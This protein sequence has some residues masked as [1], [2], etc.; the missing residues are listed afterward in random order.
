M[1]RCAVGIR[2]YLRCRPMVFSHTRPLSSSS[3]KLQQKV[4]KPAVNPVLES[5]RYERKSPIEHILL[6]PDTYVGSTA[7]AED[8]DAWVV[9]DDGTKC[10][11]TPVTYSPALLKI[12]DEILVNAADNKQRDPDMD[13]LRVD[14]DQKHGTISIVNNGRGLPIEVHPIEGIYVPTLIFGN[15]FTSSNYDDSEVKVVGGRNGYGAKLCNIFSKEFI[16]ETSSKQKG[17]VFRQRWTNNMRECAEPVVTDDVNAMDYT[18]VTFCPDVS[19]FGMEVLDDAICRMFHKRTYDVAGTLR[20]VNVFYNGQ[21]V[22]V[23]SFREYVSLYSDDSA[24]DLL[25]VNASRRWQWAVKRTSGGFQQISFVNNIATTGGGKHVDHVVDQL[26]NIIK[27][28]VDANVKSGVKRVAIK[29]HLCLFVNALIENPAFNSQTKGVLTTPVSDF[30]S[31]CAV[32]SAVVREWAERSGLVDELTSDTLAREARPQRKQRKVVS[33]DLSDIVKLED[34]NWAGNAGHMEECRLL[35]TEGDSAKAL[36]VA[37]LEVV[38]RDRYGV[39]PIMG[40]LTNVSG[41][42]EEKA[43]SAKEINHLIR[44]LGLKYGTD[45]SLRKNRQSLRYG[46]VIILTD[47]DEDGAHIKGLIINFLHTF[48]PQLIRC[49]FVQSFRTPLLKARRGSETI[50]FYSAAEFNEWK[51][52]TSDADKFTIKYYKGLGTSTSK[53]AREYFSNFQQHLTTFR[54]EDD[55]D[56]LRIR[57]VFDK[58]RSDDRK[59]W[60]TERLAASSQASAADSAIPTESRYKDFVDNELFRYSILDLRRSIPSVVDGLKPS[61]RKVIHTL[62][63]RSSNKEIKVNQLAAAV[64]LHDAYHHGEI[65]PPRARRGAAPVGEQVQHLY[66][67]SSN[68]A[69][70]PGGLTEYLQPVGVGINK[71]FMD[72]IEEATLVRN[73]LFAIS[74]ET[75]VNS[76]KKA[77]D[78]DSLLYEQFDALSVVDDELEAALVTTIVRLA[79]DFVGMNNVCLLEPLGQFGTRH[80]GGDDAASARY[81]YTKLSAFT[82][83]IFPPADDDLL[84]YLEEE[85]QSIEPQWYCPIVP[86]ILVNGAEGIATGWST[87][88]L[89]HNIRKVIDNVRRLID[90][91]KLEKMIPSFADFSGTVE[92]LE[93]NRYEIRGRFRFPPSQRK[94]APNLNLDIVELPV[95]EWTNRYKQ[96]TLHTLQSRGLISEPSAKGTTIA[97]ERAGVAHITEPRNSCRGKFAE[98]RQLFLHLGEARDSDTNCVSCPPCRWPTNCGFK[99]YHTE[100]GV[101]FEVELSKEFSVRCRKPIGRHAELMKIFKLSTVISTN[102]MVLFDPNGQLKHYAAVSDIMH[103]HFRTRQKK[104]E[105]RREYEAK[106]LDAQRRRVE[107]QLRFV[108]ATVSGEIRPQGSHLVDLENVML[109]KGFEAD[110]VK[111]WKNEKADLSY[112]LGMPL[113]RLTMEEIEKLRNQVEAS[114]SK[115]NKVMQT[116]WQDLWLED[117][118]ALEKMSGDDEEDRMCYVCSFTPEVTSDLLEELFTQVGPVEK[119]SLTDK[120]SHRF[121]MVTFEDEES[122]LFAVETL[123]GIKLFDT[124]LTV[125]PRNGSK[126]EKEYKMN[127]SAKRRESYGSSHSSPHSEHRKRDYMGRTTSYDESYTHRSGGQTNSLYTPPPPP[128]PPPPPRH[129]DSYPSFKTRTPDSFNTP[130]SSF[131]GRPGGDQRRTFPSKPSDARVFDGES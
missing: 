35:I 106:M 126:H 105:E 31:K 42:S 8:V 86:M 47:Q 84:E 29:N 75:T 9:S 43:N 67:E 122:V 121:A 61:Q 128:P 127:L 23:S 107:N 65:S 13:E 114:R 34:A 25:Y 99:E 91:V 96:N 101:H 50:S 89:S 131:T 93:E 68:V 4:K 16:V 40:K 73:N 82:R 38:G 90:N 120:K 6:R 49:G 15:L 48:W 45:Y 119:V 88:I 57:L 22:K 51:R 72:N 55:D 100:R 32:D 102:S 39:F 1:R 56:D 85:N 5:L 104:Y 54:H 11:Q 28:L 113:S 112:L 62:L 12:F 3:L 58:R 116:S 79:Q 118:Q 14:V 115:F 92:E 130:R 10:V 44:I 111:L 123:D 76:I 33:E 98:A 36:A 78:T 21:L 70:I 53:E 69:V 59:R 129:S 97:T 83:L 30:G 24:A 117:L 95:G 41:L 81:I 64:A 7:L 66:K 52:N 110:P 77:L 60:I 94:N 46:G 37:G 17:L 2:S 71:P 124:P 87:R 108:E 19:K 18:K 74:T 80:E 63:S 27:P 109:S 125:K 103:D 26:V 20:N